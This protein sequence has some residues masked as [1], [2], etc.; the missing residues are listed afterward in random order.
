MTC[1]AAP[2]AELVFVAGAGV[3]FLTIIQELED[4]LGVPILSADVALHWA[5]SKALKVNIENKSLGQ[6]L[7]F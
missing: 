2:N 7:A 6:L 3:R 5:M 1:Q 4:E